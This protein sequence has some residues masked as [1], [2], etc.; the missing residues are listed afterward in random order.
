MP[1]WAVLVL[2]A[3]TFGV[4]WTLLL[5]APGA[6]SRRVYRRLHCCRG[7]DYDLRATR[8]PMC[9]ECGEPVRS[10]RR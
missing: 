1:A 7:C 2:T 10:V 4:V 9:P 6:L 3:L 5:V 8:A